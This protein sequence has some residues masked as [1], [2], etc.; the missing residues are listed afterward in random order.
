MAIMATERGTFAS[1]STGPAFDPAKLARIQANLEQQGVTF[2]TGE[3]GARM[4][5]AFGGE[6]TYMPTPGQPGIIAWGPNPSRAAVVEELLH[7]GQHR[8]SGW[9]DLSGQV[10]GLEISA[11]NRLLGIGARLGWTDA[12]LAQIAAARARWMEGL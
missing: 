11:Q 3:E 1:G 8:A 12:E 10:V 9:A 2:V 7:L 6:A 5:R 4:A